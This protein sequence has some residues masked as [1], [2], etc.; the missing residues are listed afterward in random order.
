MKQNNEIMKNLE[1]LLSKLILCHNHTPYS[2]YKA[3]L[4][5]LAPFQHIIGP[6]IYCNNLYSL[7]TSHYPAA[8]AFLS[9][10]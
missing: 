2:F 10:L 6:I 3:R 1:L 4:P 8:S 5:Q 9:R 7:S